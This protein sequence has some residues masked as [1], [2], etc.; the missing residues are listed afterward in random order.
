MNKYR[1]WSQEDI[2]SIVNMKSEGL[3]WVDVARKIGGNPESVRSAFR[4]AVGS[5]YTAYADKLPPK[6]TQLPVIAILDIETLPMIRYS[7]SLYDDYA[8]PDQIIV[9]SCML[10]WAGRYINMPEIHSDVLTSSET[11]I[12]DKKRDTKRITESLWKFLREVDA[13]VGHNY[14]GFDL[15]RINTEFLHHGLPPLKYTVIDT[16]Q[17]ARRHFKFASNKMKFINEALGIRNKVGNDGFSLW[18]RCSEGDSTALQTMLDYNKGDIGATEELFY[19][20]RPYI[21]NFNVG[22]YNESLEYQCP[23]CGSEDLSYDERPWPTPAGLW[24]SA[25][26]NSCGCLFRL[27]YNLLDKNKKR[28]LGVNS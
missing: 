7:W 17:L 1:K 18:E 20:L 3:S 9:D 6:P 26:C 28:V 19:K 23:V 16:Y 10:S 13:V 11:R 14:A 8:S 15:L 21:K 25:R 12:Q 27:K 2:N 4:R 5:K 24:E 22:I